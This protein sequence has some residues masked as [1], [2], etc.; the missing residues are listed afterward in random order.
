L[1]TLTCRPQLTLH[2]IQAVCF[3]AFVLKGG[4]V[5]MLEA[6]YFNW[7][8]PARGSGKGRLNDGRWIEGHAIDSVRQ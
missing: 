2:R 3:H 4:V 5:V 8:G 1:S 7:G 6:P